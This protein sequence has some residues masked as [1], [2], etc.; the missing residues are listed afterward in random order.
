MGDVIQFP[1]PKNV[2]PACEYKIPTYFEIAL[3]NSD[4]SARDGM[5]EVAHIRY[6][7]PDCGAWLRWVPD[8]T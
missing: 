4:S 7:C 3:N 6:G 1:A 5:S 2:C 8:G